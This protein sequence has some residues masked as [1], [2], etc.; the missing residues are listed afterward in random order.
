MKCN[1]DFESDNFTSTE[2]SLVTFKASALAEITK[3]CI[4]IDKDKV[5]ADIKRRQIPRFAD[6]PIGQ[7]TMECIE[8]LQK[9]SSEFALKLQNDLCSWLKDFKIQEIE[10]LTDLQKLSSIQAEIQ[11]IGSLKSTDFKTSFAAVYDREVIEE[12]LKMIE[13]ALGKRFT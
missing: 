8:K 9:Y 5:I 12:E 13:W 4:K 1:P 11:E 2:H 10:L 6:A 3:T 7:S